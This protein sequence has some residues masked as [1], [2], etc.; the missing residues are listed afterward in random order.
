[1]DHRSANRANQ[2]ESGIGQAA[3]TAHSTS[4]HL[5]APST[6]PRQE[7]PVFGSR[8]TLDDPPLPEHR[9]DWSPD[10]LTAFRERL[11]AAV[12]APG[13]QVGALLDEVPDTPRNL[14]SLLEHLVDAHA[15]RA[16]ADGRARGLVRGPLPD[17]AVARVGHLLVA[18]RLTY[19]R[20]AGRR[21]VRRFAHGPS[22]GVLRPDRNGRRL[23]RHLADGLATAPA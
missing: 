2:G 10:R 7:D 3:A 6:P 15:R 1:M 17:D 13:A 11:D 20:G 21:L 5:R 23:L 22:S 9:D 19:R 14:A 12:S 16:R 4:A 8:P 18:H